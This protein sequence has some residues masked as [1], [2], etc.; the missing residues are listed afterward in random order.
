MTNKLIL[1]CVPVS[2][3]E[4]RR[5]NSVPRKNIVYHNSKCEFCGMKILVSESQ[6]KMRQQGD[7]PTWCVGCA[8][9]LRDELNKIDE[10]IW[11]EVNLKDKQ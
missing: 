11:H 2:R 6:E 5:T 4:Q 8:L 3:K 9:K 10:N 7:Y 1:G